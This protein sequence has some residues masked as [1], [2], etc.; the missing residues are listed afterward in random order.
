MPQRLLLSC[1]GPATS[2][3][4]GCWEQARR[5]TKESW[6]RMC[7]LSCPELQ[8]HSSSTLFLLG[9]ADLVR[10]C[11]CVCSFPRP[12]KCHTSVALARGPKK[13]F[14]VQVGEAGLT[15][16]VA[17]SFLSHSVSLPLS[18]LYRHLS[19]GDE[20]SKQRAMA[21]GTRQQV[22]FK[23]TQPLLLPKKAPSSA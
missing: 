8:S 23:R 4:M 1:N 13:A 16:A 20:V 6:V 10:C 19:A 11:A 7:M 3:F 14:L 18:L 15:K 5:P 21:G 12:M 9:K 17:L 22:C 2:C